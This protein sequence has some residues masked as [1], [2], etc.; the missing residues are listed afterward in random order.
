M[1]EIIVV[2]DLGHFKAYRV[3][4]APLES[5]RIE[6]LKSYDAVAA[7]GRLGEKLSDKAGR[8]GAKGG[9]NGI[10]GYGEPHNIEQENKRRLVKQIAENISMI[11]KEGK[12]K[13]WHLAAS[14][15]INNQIIGNLDPSVKSGLDKNI[16]SD[17]TKVRKSDILDYFI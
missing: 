1:N 4:R 16:L 10:K 17:L 3:S 5:A 9:K 13:K 14:G 11:V 7:H 6:M 15:N 12:F 2:A 8:F